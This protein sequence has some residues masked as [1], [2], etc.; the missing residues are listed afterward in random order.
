MPLWLVPGFFISAA[1]YATAGFGGGSS[2][3]AL[4][5]LS[6]M[7]FESVAVL[8]LLCNILVVGGNLLHYRQA[9]LLSVKP[10]LP[11]LVSSVPLAALGGSLPISE[12]LFSVLLGFCL[13]LVGLRL[14]LGHHGNEQA[15]IS[16]TVGLRWLIGVPV[17]G[18]LGFI[19]GLVGIG[20]GILLAP[21]L[22]FLRWGSARSIAA[23]CSLF[24][25]INSLAGLAGHFSNGSVLALPAAAVWLF[26]A[27]VAG[28]QLGAHGS[29][30]KLPV[31]MLRRSTAIIVLAAGGR[32][33]WQSL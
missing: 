30:F 18:I 12:K 17:G 9:G 21:I 4:L 14:W 13:A 8:A 10:L 2:Y 26:A 16:P 33:L 28:G 24:I 27:V 19:A 15:A 20:G 11:F 22:Y 32:L 29:A 7:P 31:W 6:G 25:L 5:V 1:A 3:L 23:H